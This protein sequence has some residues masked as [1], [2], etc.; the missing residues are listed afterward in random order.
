MASGELELISGSLAIARKI[1]EFLQVIRLDS[2]LAGDDLRA[3]SDWKESILEELQKCAVIIAVLSKEFKESDWCPQELGIFYSQN[4]KIIPISADGTLPFGFINNIQARPIQSRFLND[5]SLELIVSEG[6]MECVA[7][8]DAF[9]HLVKIA[10]SFEK[11]AEIFEAM[12]PYFGSF[13]KDAVN[14]I[15]AASIENGQVWKADKC[16]DEYLPKLLELRKADI[17]TVLMEKITY[18]ITKGSWYQR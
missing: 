13:E 3:A 15:I 2:F 11:A 7:N 5:L 18:Q 12:V 14:S 8:G 10:P 9:A 1:Q 4:K 17:D 6:L 16:D